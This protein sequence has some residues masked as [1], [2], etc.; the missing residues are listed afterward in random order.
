MAKILLVGYNPPQLV[1]DRKIE[2]ANYR[3]WQF[4]QPL[5]DDGN[6]ICL[7]AGISGDKVQK[8]AL[9]EIWGNKVIYR[10]ITF[11]AGLWL[12]E[13]QEAHDA[14]D[15]DCIVAVNFSHCLYVTKLRTNKPIWM[16]IYGETITIVQAA[17]YRAQSDRGLSTT[18]GFMRDVLRTGDVFSGCSSQQQHALVGELAMA[19]RLNRLTFGYDFTNVILP[20]SPPSIV[21]CK[22]E[23]KERS[24]LRKFGL[25]NEDFVIVWCGGYNTWTDVDTLFAGLEWAMTKSPV[26]HYI[27]VGGSTYSASDNV[28]KTFLSMIEQSNYRDRFHMLG[29]RPWIEV[30]D[31]Y[32]ESNVGLNVDALHYETIYGTRTRLV[33]MIAAGLPIITSLGTELSYKLKESKCAL[34]FTHGDWQALGK[35]FLRLANDREYCSE[36]ADKSNNYASNELSFYATTAPLRS[37]VQMPKL[38]PDNL[39]R[40]FRERRLRLQH[41]TRSLVRHIIWRA[42]SLDK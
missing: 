19:G 30:F 9:S 13:L 15:P 17:C 42:F 12:K 41:K 4:L 6:E 34:T 25:S 14:F 1:G 23:N 32:R 29:W 24:L 40:N 35:Q 21:S 5:I 18:I 7:C 33:E 2:A 39:M 16:D 28:Y 22:H 36:L 27:S 31:I 38:A 11:G 3:T 26:I 8:S 10:P 20:G 37:W